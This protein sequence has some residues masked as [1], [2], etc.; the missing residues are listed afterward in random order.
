M[1][2]VS[3][4]LQNVPKQDTSPSNHRAK[5]EIRNRVLAAVG[6]ERA[7]VL[8]CFAGEGLMFREV[9]S[10]A[11]SCIGIDRRFFPDDRLCFV[12][13]TE[14]VL[15]SLDVQEFT[16]FD[17][18]AWGSPWEQL[19]II[20]SRR[21]LAPGEVIGVVITEGQGIK[22]KMGGMSHALAKM[23]GMR[24][25]MPGMGSAQHQ[26]MDRAIA[27]IARMTQSTILSRWQAVGKVG[28]SIFYIG[29]VLRGNSVPGTAAH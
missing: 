15:R 21:R 24:P 28:S 2:K 5:V 8:D 25:N 12:G 16:I 22:L 20:A 10:K 1:P 18:D 13:E 27:A 29:L 14:R 23:A 6:P 9:W 26:A 11:A 7:R 3:A 19:Y 17:C 4:L